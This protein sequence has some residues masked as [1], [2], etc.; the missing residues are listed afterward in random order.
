MVYSKHVTAFRITKQK[1]KK[2]IVSI[3]FCS[4]H[5]ELTSCGSIPRHLIYPTATRAIETP[6]QTPQHTRAELMAET[7]CYQG[8]NNTAAAKTAT[9]DGSCA[10]PRRYW[11]TSNDDQSPPRTCHICGSAWERVTRVMSCCLRGLCGGWCCCSL[12][13]RKAKGCIKIWSIS[14]AQVLH[15]MVYTSH[16][17]PL[18][19]FHSELRAVYSWI[20][21]R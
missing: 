6:K 1:Y 10:L 3:S 14:T 9:S 12:K 13:T 19:Q 17:L 7:R 15:V 5:P 21:Q 20:C 16:Y 2:K 8:A 4:I 11:A 18:W